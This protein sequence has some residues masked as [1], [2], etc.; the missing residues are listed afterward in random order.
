MLTGEFVSI[1]ERDSRGERDAREEE[2][3]FKEL[4]DSFNLEESKLL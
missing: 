4:V 3:E 1:L 2:M